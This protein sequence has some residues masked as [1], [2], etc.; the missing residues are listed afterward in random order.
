MSRNNRHVSERSRVF[1]SRSTRVLSVRC[2]D[3]DLATCSLMLENL[4][5]E[6][7]TISDLVKKVL[8]MVALQVEEHREEPLTIT[9]ARSYLA[10]RFGSVGTNRNQQAYN[11]AANAEY[12]RLKNG[13]QFQL[14]PQQSFTQEM[15]TE[16]FETPKIAWAEQVQY[17]QYVIDHKLNAATFTV[18]DWKDAKRKDMDSLKAEAVQRYNTVHGAAQEDLD[19]SLPIAVNDT[20]EELEERVA[21]R[22]ERENAEKLA[23]EQ[24]TQGLLNGQ[25]NS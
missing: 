21:E 12:L 18:E 20:P 9:E 4:G 1:D 16:G 19:P 22:R 24:F 14:Q 2:N 5:I 17:T 3:V 10:E 11:E 8:R 7:L 13:P 6:V 23:M 25:K 15:P